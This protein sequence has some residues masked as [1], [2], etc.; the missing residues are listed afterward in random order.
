MLKL[1]KKMLHSLKSLPK[2][3]AYI[4]YSD[5]FK[6]CFLQKQVQ[7]HWTVKIM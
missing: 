1:F 2:I 5:I 3:N 6:W 4:N 7:E